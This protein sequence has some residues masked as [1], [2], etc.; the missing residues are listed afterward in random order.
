MEAIG[1]NSNIIR[2][3]YRPPVI[4]IYNPPTVMH[5]SQTISPNR[6][7]SSTTPNSRMRL[8]ETILN[9]L[10]Y[11][12]IARAV[13]RRLFE[14]SIKNCILMVIIKIKGIFRGKNLWSSRIILLATVWCNLALK[15]GRLSKRLTQTDRS[16]PVTKWMGGW[17]VRW[18]RNRRAREQVIDQE[19]M[20]WYQSTHKEMY[21]QVLVIFRKVNRV[22]KCIVES[23]RTPSSI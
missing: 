4:Q 23:S 5:L 9:P 17:M 15:M 16:W 1:I 22:I 3:G 11:Q 14:R 12:L 21:H 6:W 19:L 10:C 8:S 18:G 13:T 20:A 2:V 7:S